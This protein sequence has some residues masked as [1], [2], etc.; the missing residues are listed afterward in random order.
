MKS[1]GFPLEDPAILRMRWVSEGC[2]L[3]MSSSQL[4][5]VGRVTQ[6]TYDETPFMRRLAVLGSVNIVEANVHG[7]D[8]VNLKVRFSS[9][10]GA[11]ICL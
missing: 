4:S 11:C 1:L 8:D 9:Q 5:T 6:P 7:L 10:I 2:S 3:E